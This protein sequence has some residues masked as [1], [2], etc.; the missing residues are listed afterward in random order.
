M[1]ADPRISPD[2]IL[3]GDHYRITP[4]TPALVRLE[5]SPSGRFEDRPSTLALHRP[6]L[7]DGVEVGRE[8]DRLI[9]RTAAYTLEYD[10]GPFRPDGLSLQVRGGVTNYHSVWRYGQDLSLP[11]HAQG[12]RRGEPTRVLNGNLGGAARTLDEA[13]GEIPLEPGVVSTTG[14][15]VLDDSASMVFDANGSLLPRDAEDGQVDLYVFAHGHD[16]V[17]ALTDF[18]LLSG[19]QPLLPRFALGNWWSRYHRYDEAG[20]LALMDRFRAEGVPF[21][22]AVIDMDWH[23]TEV[24]P[25]YGSGWTGYTWNR[26]LFPDPERFQR[27]LHERGLAVT[28]NVHPADGVRAFEDA[29][30]AMCEALGRPVDGE[31]IAF[32]AADPEF[33]RAYFEVLHRGLEEQGTD[34][35]WVD[36]QSGPYSRRRGLDPLWVLNH[37]HFTDNARDGRRGLTFSRYAGPGSHRYPVGFSGDAIISWESLAFQPRFTAAGANIGY[38]WWSHDIGGHME[39]YRDDE[40]AARWVQFGCFSPILRLHSSNSPFAG[41]EPWNFEPAA[42]RTMVEHLRLRHRMLPYL[43]AMN[44]RAHLEGRSLVEPTYITTPVDQAYRYRDQYSFG[45]QLLVAP[46][47]RPAA[48]DTRLGAA[49]AYLPEGDWVDVMTGL[50]YRG[51]RVL[52][53][54]RDLSSIP[55]LLRAGGFLPL[56][57]EGTDLWSAERMP[58]L[59]ILVAVGADG[60]FSL[61]EEPVDG[62]WVETRLRLEAEAGRLVIDR[63]GAVD[64]GAAGS[65]AGAGEGTGQGAG[66]ADRRGRR[67]FTVTL[68]G[69]DPSALQDLQCG[70]ARVALREADTAGPPGGLGRV[71][72]DLQP[73][74]EQTPVVLTSA[75]LRRL[76]PTDPAPRVRRLLERAQ[77]GYTLKERLMAAVEQRGVAA[78]GEIAAI[79]SAPMGHAP[80]THAYEQPSAELIAAVA[81]ILTA[82]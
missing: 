5:W 42:E 19:P 73:D 67:A 16:H 31:P 55:V 33:L 34:F 81:E 39:G 37:G 59:E 51:G 7:R 25:R 32:D 1:T 28:L 24:D 20:Y 26:D 18:H 78:L 52:R 15:A 17:Q 64:T 13:D 3:R 46:I 57:A 12:R 68:L 49:D 21:S 2:G 66:A 40:L 79:G 4:I 60:E 11:A 38:G 27:A 53:L 43:H 65:T 48:A 69:A 82:R 71:H 14:Y 62:A 23:L 47:V 75:A 10:E 74:D 54:H 76:A 22:V 58:D 6:V 77:I 30:P 9:V 29:Y 8:G 80:V 50:A 56:A 41:K 63:D 72:L 44:R 36:W 70:G 45:S 61:W 35:W